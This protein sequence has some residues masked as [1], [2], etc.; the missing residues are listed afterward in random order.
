M[1]NSQTRL[2]I[3]L[4]QNGASLGSYVTDGEDKVVI[5]SASQAD[6]IVPLRGISKIHAML[7]VQNDNL[8]IY[9]LGS[10]QGTFVLG[11]KIIERALNGNEQIRLGTHELRVE[12]L[13][14]KNENAPEQSLFWESLGSEILS[15]NI[16]ENGLLQN[17]IHLKNEKCINGKDLYFPELGINEVFISRQKNIASCVLPKNFTAEIY[18]QKNKL[19]KKSRRREF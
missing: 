9:D 16:I 1:K 3:E 6:F 15:V 12:T 14:D 10:E 19:I 2:R 8:V 11:H 7:R 17:I 4:L 5:G 13:R 18:D